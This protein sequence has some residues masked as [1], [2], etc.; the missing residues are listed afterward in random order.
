VFFL[1]LLNNV[2][3]LYKKYSA[4][5][6]DSAPETAQNIIWMSSVIFTSE[7]N[8]ISERVATMMMTP[9]TLRG[10]PVVTRKVMC[11]E[12]K[13]YLLMTLM[14]MLMVMGRLQWHVMLAAVILWLSLPAAVIV[15]P[16]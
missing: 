15:A 4:G 5:N 1:Q 12:E 8:M 14:L 10:I 9:Q 7:L 6:I 2:T 13:S 16:P 3:E 11:P